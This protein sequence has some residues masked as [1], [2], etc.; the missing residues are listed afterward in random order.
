MQRLTTRL[1]NKMGYVPQP[2]LLS[3]DRPFMTATP[4]RV[5]IS[6]NAHYQREIS[7]SSKTGVRLVTA[8][9]LEDP[10]TDIQDAIA[11]HH[12][13]WL[14]EFTAFLVAFCFF[15]KPF[16]F[17]LIATA[18]ATRQ[19]FVERTELSLSDTPVHRGACSRIGPLALL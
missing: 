2:D 8:L 4:F 6:P 15:N 19:K 13:V 3:K 10:V 17:S 12:I 11:T 16:L 1:G 18:P 5:E 14:E 9:H 7:N